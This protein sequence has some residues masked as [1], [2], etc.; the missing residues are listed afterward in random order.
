MDY[1]KEVSEHNLEK[2][3]EAIGGFIEFFKIDRTIDETECIRRVKSFIDKQIKQFVCRQ[4]TV[5]TKQEFLNQIELGLLKNRKFFWGFNVKDRVIQ[6]I[7]Q[8]DSFILFYEQYL[9]EKSASILSSIFLSFVRTD[10]FLNQSSI[11]DTKELFFAEFR[12]Y[13]QNQISK[14]HPLNAYIQKQLKDEGFQESVFRAVL[15]YSRIISNQRRRTN[16]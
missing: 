10:S 11:S 15:T 13:L 6:K 5:V 2:W 3:Q 4:S 1:S 8:Q 16:E 7:L 14:N 12:G 9:K